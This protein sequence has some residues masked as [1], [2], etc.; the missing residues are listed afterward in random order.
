MHR[1]ERPAF[2]PAPRAR[3]A[4]A[5]GASRYDPR[6]PLP[7]AR[8]H[9]SF[10][11]DP[12]ARHDVRAGRRAL[13]APGHAVGAGRDARAQAPGDRARVRAAHD[14]LDALAAAGRGRPRPRGAAGAG[15]RVHHALHAQGDAHAHDGRRAQPDRHQRLP[16]V[17]PAAGRR[18]AAVGGRGRRR[19][20]GAG[21][22]Q[23]A[24]RRGTQR[25]P[26]R[27]RRRRARARPPTRSTRPAA[28]CSC[29]AG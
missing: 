14:G 17:V 16:D 9:E 12:R 24:A 22:R 15:G 25:R 8:I 18:R 28:A 3:P 1:R 13:P 6:S 20:L 19:R 4:C 11:P 23:P 21:R 26:L 29:T 5:D 27:P 2:E 7:P 10:A